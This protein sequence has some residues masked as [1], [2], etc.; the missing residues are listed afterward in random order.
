MLR[1]EFEMRKKDLYENKYY[2][3][4][5]THLNTV[6]IYHFIRNM[7]PLLRD[8]FLGLLRTNLGDLLYKDRYQG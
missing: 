2:I 8:L 4:N 7:Y 6:P 5:L 3:G 1:V